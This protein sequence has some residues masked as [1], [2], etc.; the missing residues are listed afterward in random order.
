MPC[1][2]RTGRVRAEQLIPSNPLNCGVQGSS[3]ARTATPKSAPSPHACQESAPSR[4]KQLLSP[5]LRR[6]RRHLAAVACDRHAQNLSQPTVSPAAAAYSS[7]AHAA[8]AAPVHAAANA[9]AAATAT[10]LA[11]AA[12]DRQPAG[13]CVRLQ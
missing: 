4:L 1:A 2:A 7:A 5:Q 8:A 11:T 10:V 9:V 6:H 3:F 12:A 13:H